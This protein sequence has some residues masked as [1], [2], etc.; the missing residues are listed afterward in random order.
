MLNLLVEAYPKAPKTSLKY[1]TPLEMLVSTILS[2][3]CTDARVNIV[4][5]KLFKKYRRPEDYANARLTD[6]EA[7][8][9]ST[10]FYRNKARNIRNSARKIIEEY[11]GNVPD[12]MGD[13]LKL[14][15]VARKTANIV[16]YN[17]FGKVEGIAVDTHVRRISYRMGL[18]GSKDPVRIEQDLMKTYPKSMWGQVNRILVEHGRQTCTARKAKCTECPIDALCPKKDVSS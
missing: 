14:P 9:R 10:G 12:S 8:I 7:D 2:A 16:L 1:R 18:T 3:Q 6:L 11:G 15:G 4:T 13:L 5:K 17:S